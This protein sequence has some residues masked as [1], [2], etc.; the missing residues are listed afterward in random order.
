M[1]RQAR[2][3]GR[4]VVLAMWLAVGFAHNSAAQVFHAQAGTSTLYDVDGGSLTIQGRGFDTTIG[5]GLLDDEL[6]I[7]GRVRTTRGRVQF[8][9]GDDALEFD[10][11]TDVFGGAHY[12]PTRGIGLS[13]AGRRGSIT[14]LAG[15]TSTRL[16]SPFFQA[17]T[18]DDPAAIVFADRQIG[19]RWRA[20]SR[21]ILSRTVTSLH[22]AEYETGYGLQV[23]GV[24][25]VGGGDPYAALG[26]VFDRSRLRASAAYIATHSSFRRVVLTSLSSTEA[27]GANA[28]VDFRPLAGWSLR[29]AHQNAIDPSAHTDRAQVQTDQVGGGLSVARFRIAAGL[30]SSRSAVACVGVHCVRPQNTGS[31][32]SIGRAF[33]R[34]DATA[35][36]YRSTSSSGRTVTTATGTFR[37]SL[38]PMISLMQIVT[39]TGGQTSVGV[40]GTLQTN[41]LSASLDY[42][43]VYAPFRLEDP[44]VRAMTAS[45]RVQPFGNWQFALVST[46]LPNGS[47]RYTASASQFFYRGANLRPAP[48]TVTLPRYAVRGRV[49]DQAGRPISRAVLQIAGTVVLTGDDGRFFSRLRQGSP[50]PLKVLTAEFPPPGSYV[51][52]SAPLMLTPTT[53][54]TGEGDVIVVAR[55]TQAALR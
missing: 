2:S 4:G 9:A 24:A 17:G 29:A 52:V 47:V 12:V 11:P 3:C 48:A 37:E 6:R 43:T 28:S 14:A 41:L 38:G 30:Y 46:V 35:S 53:Q 27:V 1:S 33:G 50:V 25:G 55:D 39:A 7:G 36:G 51:V 15:A 31:S 16:G 23:S 5:L 22:G 45:L 44:F 10:L 40:G 54:N 21:N 26:T 42:Q 49:V 32:L 8:I 20:I 13:T 19:R 18:W 34:I